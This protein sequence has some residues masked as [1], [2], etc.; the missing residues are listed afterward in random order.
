MNLVLLM[1]ACRDDAGG[2]ID[3]G[4]A[5]PPTDVLERCA[6]WRGG[7]FP[8][9]YLPPPLRLPTE[10]ALPPHDPVR[11][12]TDGVLRQE[13]H[14][15]NH[16]A[17]VT[18]VLAFVP[19]GE[20]TGTYVYHLH[21]E[22]PTPTHLVLLTD[23]REVQVVLEGAEA[24]AVV[25]VFTSENVQLMG[26]PSIDLQMRGAHVL[27]DRELRFIEHRLLVD[28]ELLV[29]SMHVVQGGGLVTLEP[30]DTQVEPMRAP[31]C[32][33]V[34]AVEREPDPDWLAATCPLAADGDTVC[35]SFDGDRLIVFDP[36]YPVD[37]RFPVS[38]T[39]Y[40]DEWG[41]FSGNA[42]AFEW[43]GTKLIGCTQPNSDGVLFRA[44]LERGDLETT[45]VPCRGVRATPCGLL[46]ERTNGQDQDSM[47]VL[48]PSFEA[49]RC[50]AVGTR[51]SYATSKFG[52]F[53]VRESTLLTE[54]WGIGMGTYDLA[55]VVPGANAWQDAQGIG[56]YPM[57]DGVAS[58]GGQ[59]WVLHSCPPEDDWGSC[60]TRIDAEGV[61]RTRQFGDHLRGLDCEVSPGR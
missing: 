23:A 43:S 7:P 55:G 61:L 2:D 31:A 5:T 27:W 3:S 60:L 6:T 1:F 17:S 26:A 56:F 11:V 28:H 19:E 37:C 59:D 41:G 42:R 14:F 24:A 13:V 25:Q 30:G 52:N 32:G 34:S 35:A 16:A 38:Q 46:V 49:A 54:T 8:E 39:V 50:G 10:L 51:L 53:D 36:E 40:T 57:A 15:E 47:F 29:D 4:P 9:D 18:R 22:D 20:P 45:F 44:D 21:M 48:Y 12:V 33:S 58:S